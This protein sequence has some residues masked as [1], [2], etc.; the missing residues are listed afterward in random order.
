MMPRARATP[1]GL[2]DPGSSTGITTT[3]AISLTGE[4]AGEHFG[5]ALS[6]AGDVDG[7]GY[8]DLLVGAEG[9]QYATGKAYLD[10]WHLC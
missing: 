4:I 9:Y 6:T 5:Y 7:D 10:R 8:A 2:T 1:A 3:G